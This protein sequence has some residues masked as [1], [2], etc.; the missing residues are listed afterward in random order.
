MSEKNIA[1]I[2]ERNKDVEHIVNA[3]AN[4]GHYGFGKTL[5]ERFALLVTAD[6][7]RCRKEIVSAIDYLN[8]MRALDAGI[9]LGDMQGSNF[10][11]ND[12]T[13][14]TTA[15]NMS[16]KPFYTVVG[17]HDGGNSRKADIS[18]TKQQVFDKFFKPTSEQIG[19][20][21]LDKTY[22]SVKFDKYKVALIVLDSYDMPDDRDENGDFVAVRFV[23]CIG[24]EQIDWLV[25]ELSEIPQ[26][27]HVIIARHSFPGETVACKG[28]WTGDYTLDKYLKAYVGEVIPDIVNAWMK[29]KSLEKEYPLNTALGKEVINDFSVFPQT[30]NVNADFTS[31]GEGVFAGYII[32]HEHYDYQ[33]VSAVYSEQQV[34]FFQ[35]SANDT[36]Q[37]YNSDLPRLEGTKA[38]DCI[39][40]IT[41]DHENRTLYMV[42]VGSNITNKLVDRT[43]TSFKY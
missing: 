4:A 2:I 32:G 13:W 24:H 36:W 11:E 42:R 15:V 37:N 25:K 41:I 40:V 1:P 6:I 28:N 34:H 12:G 22:Y 5:D 18:A 14:Y 39:T 26:D 35:S 9:C 3:A 31:R 7:H 27:Y 33:C 17:N 20:E 38:E 10:S 23:E 21:G 16:Q 8:G 19:I 43:Y 30:L 29:G